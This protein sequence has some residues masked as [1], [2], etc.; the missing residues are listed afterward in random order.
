M[1]RIPAEL[2][3][4]M[5]PRVAT[6]AVEVSAPKTRPCGL[7]RSFSSACIIPG[8]TE[9]RCSSV[10]TSKTCCIREVSSVSPGAVACPARDVPVPRGVMESPISRAAASVRFTSSSARAATTPTGL[11]RYM[12]PSV[13]QRAREAGSVRK[14]PASLPAR[15]ARSRSTVRCSAFSS[16]MPESI[17]RG[18]SLWDGGWLIAE[19]PAACCAYLLDKTILAQEVLG[20]VFGGQPIH[21]DLRVQ[22][23]HL[24]GGEERGDGREQVRELLVLVE[25]LP[26]YGERGV[27]G[28]EVVLVVYQEHEVQVGDAPVGRKDRAEVALL[29]VGDL[30]VDEAV[31]DTVDLVLGELPAVSLL[32]A[33][34]PVVAIRELAAHA[35]GGF[36]RVLVYKCSEVRE[37]LK[38]VL[39]GD[40]L[41]RGD[42]VAVLLRRDLQPPDVVLFEVA[43]GHGLVVV[44][45]Y[46]T[47]GLAQVVDPGRTHV[48]PVHIDLTGGQRRPG[49]IRAGQTDLVVHR[50]PGVL[51]GQPGY[52]AQDQLLGEL[53]GADSVL[54]PGEIVLLPDAA[55]TDDASTAATAHGEHRQGDEQQGDE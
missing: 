51:Q 29:S 26:A 34:Q 16:I 10:F 9:Q 14:Y 45:R 18:R 55:P 21:V 37:V 7:T 20:H 5:P 27:V 30:I 36:V 48:L 1:E 4:T 2:L 19:P 31:L 6:F 50:S 33:R 44:A 53:L 54:I 39:V 38:A 46:G 22:P 23:L 15:A 40:L 8:S 25:Y 11:L 35:Q 41:V 32:H 52:V 3:P 24:L 43:V 42:S 17:K 28:R 47:A 13:D 49:S 12:E